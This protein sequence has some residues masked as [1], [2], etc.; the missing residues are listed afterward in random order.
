MSCRQLDERKEE[1]MRRFFIIGLIG[2]LL[3][4]TSIA[5]AHNTPWAWTQPGAARMVRSDATVQLPRAE[6]ASLESELRQRVR[7]YLLLATAEGEVGVPDAVFG[8]LYRQNLH[9]IRKVRNGLAIVAA[10]CKGSGKAI[11]ANRFKH[12]R[13]SAT[14]ETIEIPT[15]EIVPPEP[16]SELPTAID[17]PPLVV[18]PLEAQFDIHVTGRSWMR[19][20]QVE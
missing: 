20:A 5:F 1:I 8:E 3:A 2:A 7:L 18:G 17:G 4:S 11:Q 19:Y 12:F 16:G 13:C 9:A 10:A 6:K 14:S 15:A